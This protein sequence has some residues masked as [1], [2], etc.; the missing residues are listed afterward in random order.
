VTGNDVDAVARLSDQL[1][2]LTLRPVDEVPNDVVDIGISP[3]VVDTERV[4]LAILTAS[5]A[6]RRIGI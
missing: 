5:S 4:S 6:L 1:R 2:E 3:V